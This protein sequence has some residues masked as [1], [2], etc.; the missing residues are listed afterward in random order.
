MQNKNNYYIVVKCTEKKLK[1]IIKML[2][3]SD[4]NYYY[5]VL[6]ID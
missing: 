3:K 6:Q 4:Q 2:V 1:Q 5:G